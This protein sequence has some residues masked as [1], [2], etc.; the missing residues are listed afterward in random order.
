[1]KRCPS[2]AEE[3]QDA[4][5]VCRFC[6]RDLVGKEHERVSSQRVYVSTPAQQKRKP[7]KFVRHL[8]ISLGLIFIGLLVI[9]AL[10]NDRTGGVEKSYKNRLESSSLPERALLDSKGNE[11]CDDFKKLRL[12]GEKNLALNMINLGVNAS[13]SSDD[14]MKRSGKVIAQYIACDGNTIISDCRDVSK[15]EMLQSLADI[16][17]ICGYAK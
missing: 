8:L 15:M 14:I 2:C 12:Q 11:A 3:I 1:M 7:D 9:A 10:V 13:N 16:E 4:A 6:N 17:K 5:I